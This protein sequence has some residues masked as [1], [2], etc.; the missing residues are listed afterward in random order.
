[1]QANIQQNKKSIKIAL[2][3]LLVTF[4][5]LTSCR[6]EYSIDNIGE[7]SF[8]TNET[9]HIFYSWAS[10]S[11]IL[12]IDSSFIDNSWLKDTT[13]FYIYDTIEQRWS[14]AVVAVNCRDTSLKTAHYSNWRSPIFHADCRINEGFKG[15]L[16][17][18]P[19][20]DKFKNQLC[21]APWRMPTREDF[22]DLNFAMRRLSIN[23]G[24]TLSV[25]YVDGWG[26]EFAGYSDGQNK[27]RSQGTH[28]MYWSQTRAPDLR[29]S[30][31]SYAL[32]INSS[33]FATTT[34]Y[35]VY[36]GFTV[37]CIKD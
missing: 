18:W 14:D 23:S 10:D 33:N 35:N 2:S 3:L 34:Y 32:I 17:T 19:A 27:L 20:V 31:F 15:H 29:G 24:T 8:A 6:K 37:R 22:L 16:F 13:W 26:A 7:T 5:L 9:W 36:R 11:S 21:P 30:K 1:M 12:Q 28:V 4:V 25:Q